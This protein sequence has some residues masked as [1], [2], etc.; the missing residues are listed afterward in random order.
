MRGYFT[1]AFP[2][3]TEFTLWSPTRLATSAEDAITCSMSSF[4]HHLCFFSLYLCST[5]FSGNVYSEICYDPN[6]MANMSGDRSL[7]PRM[8]TGAYYIVPKGRESHFGHIAGTDSVPVVPSHISTDKSDQLYRHH[9][10]DG[11]TGSS[12]SHNDKVARRSAES[13][14]PKTSDVFGDNQSNITS[15]TGQR[16]DSECDVHPEVGEASSERDENEPQSNVHQQPGVTASKKLERQ[17]DIVERNKIT[18]GLNSFPGGSYKMAYAHK[19]GRAHNGNKVRWQTPI[20]S[21]T[22]FCSVALLHFFILHSSLGGP[23]YFLYIKSVFSFLFTVKCR[24]KL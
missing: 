14:D 6:T 4:F 3:M 11:R 20:L 8:K 19:Q 16:R 15:Q 1:K 13:D 12:S 23:F 10:Q 18:L 21:G 24:K 22:L 2:L 17:G 9:P 7:G 5:M